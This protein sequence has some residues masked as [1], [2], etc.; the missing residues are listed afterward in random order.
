MPIIIYNNNVILLIVYDLF[1]FI[2]QLKFPV[3]LKTKKKKLVQVNNENSYWTM[4]Y[5]KNY[6]G[7]IDKHLHTNH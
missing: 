3:S 6:L 4:H 1:T 2:S 5:K 7:L